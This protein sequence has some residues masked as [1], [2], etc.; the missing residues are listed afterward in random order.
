MKKICLILSIFSAFHLPTLYIYANESE[1][2]LIKVGEFNFE[3]PP[4]SIK[5]RDYYIDKTE[6]TQKAF[7]KVMGPTNFFFKGDTK[8]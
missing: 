1:M 7:Q 3:K 2:V 6:V 8:S 5:L 4:K